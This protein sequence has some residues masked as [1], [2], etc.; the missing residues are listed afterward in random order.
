MS[1]WYEGTPSDTDPRYSLA[2]YSMLLTSLIGVAGNVFA[3]Y[4]RGHPIVPE[5]APDAVEPTTDQV[6]APA[7]LNI[8]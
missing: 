3:I 2:K 8:W 6:D 1:K 4:L 5:V 7:E